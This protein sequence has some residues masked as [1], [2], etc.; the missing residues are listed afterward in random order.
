MKPV[1]YIEIDGVLWKVMPDGQWIAVQADEVVDPTVKYVKETPLP[2]N[3]SDAVNIDDPIDADPVYQRPTTPNDAQSSDQDLASESASLFGFIRPEL[4]EVL[5]QSGYDTLPTDYENTPER[6][7]PDAQFYLLDD[8]ATITVTI[9]DGG[10]GY[11]NALEVPSIAIFGTTTDVEDGRIVQ[12]VLSD[13]SGQQQVFSATVFQGEYRIEGIDA[14]GF[15]EGTL[16]VTATI[17]DELDNFIQA[18]DTTIKDTLAEITTEFDG[19]GDEFFNRF[20]I[21]SSGLTGTVSHVED[22]QRIDIEVIDSL[23]QTLRFTTRVNGGIWSINE[24]LSSLAEGPLTIHA[25][26]IDVAGNP[27]SASDTIV[28]DTQASIT[29]AIDSADDDLVSDAESGNVRVYGEVTNVE[30]GQAIRVVLVDSA[31]HA[32]WF[33]TSVSG[34]Q[35]SI[36]NIDV[37]QF[38]DGDFRVLAM[39]KDVAGNPA[40]AT[41]SA[42]LDTTFPTIDIDTLTGLQII[43][44]K[45]GADTALQGTTSG[46]EAGQPVLVTITDGMNTVEVLT[47]VDAAGN[48]SFDSIDLSTLDAN[49]EWQLNATVTDLAG[50]RASDDMPSLMVPDVVNVNE[51]IAVALGSSD[52][53]SQINIDN[54]DF[55]FID[56]QS[57]L[58]SL[59]SLGQSISVVLSADGLSLSAL[60]ADG[61][62]VLSAHILNNQEV[63]I[64]LFLPVD[65]GDAQRLLTELMIQGTQTDSDGTSETVV[66]PVAVVI[67]DAI[68]FPP[69][70]DSAAITVTIDDGGDGYEN[71]QETPAVVIHGS[72]TDVENLRLVTITVTDVD[73]NTLTFT[74][75]VENNRYQ[76]SPV[77]L[78]GLAEGPLSVEAHIDDVYGKTIQ[79]TDSTIKDTLADITAEFEGN[80]DA[81]LNQFEVSKTVLT[82]RVT[83]VEDGQRIDI[84]VID[85]L[86]NTLTFSTLVAGNTWTIE[87]DLSSLVDGELTLTTQ[88]IDVAGN[89]TTASDTIIKDTQA[90]ITIAIDSGEDEALNPTELSSVTLS[91]VVSHVEDGQAVQVVVTDASGA[92]LVFTTVVVSGAWSLT[93]LDLSSLTDGDIHATARTIDVAGNPATAEDTAIVDTTAP[94]ID[95][96]TLTGLGIVQFKQGTETALQG[97]TTGAEPGQPVVVTISDGTQTI[98]VTTTVDASGLWSFSSIDVS[99]LDAA[100]SWTLTATVTDAAGNSASDETPTLDI[101]DTVALWEDVAVILDSSEALSDINIDN[102]LFTF[103]DTQSDLAALTSLGQSVS[104]VISTDGLSLSLVRG[105]GATVLAAA[106]ETNSQV[107]L[108]LFLPVDHGEAQRL[109]TQIL[110]EGT[111]TD[112][113]GTTETVIAPLPI[114]IED[115]I[116][117]PPLVDSASLTVTIDDGGDGYEN[118]LEVPGTRIHGNTVDVQDLRLVTITVTDSLGAT[119]TFTTRVEN[120]QYQFFPVDLSSLA[121]G[122]LTVEAEI[123][124]AYGNVITAND[125]TIKDTLAEMD[126]AFDGQGD[127]FLNQFEVATTMLNGH[128]ANVEDGQTI[129]IEIIDGQGGRLTFTTVVSGEQWSLEVDLSTLSDGELTVHAQTL[130]VAGNPT[131]SHHTIVKDTQ[132]SI[133]V[134]IESGDDDL[135]NPEELTSVKVGGLV[136][137]IE[138]GQSVNVVLSDSAGNTMTLQTTIVGGAWAIENLDLSGFVDGEI[139]ATVSTVD[140]AGNPATATDSATVDTTAPTID[141]DTLD[142]LNILQFKLGTSTALQGTT[143]GAEAGQPVVV[144]ISDGTQSI[145]ITTSVDAAGNWQF[146]AIDVSDLNN[147]ATWTLT[148]TVTDAAGNSAVDD[149]PTLTF[150]DVVTVYEDL[151]VAIG[152]SGAT[153]DINVEQAQFRFHD[154]QTDLESLTSF[155][156]SITTTLSADGQTL[157]ATRADGEILLT[158]HIASN[159]QVQLQLFLPVDH[160]DSQRLLT[161]LMIAG[162]QTDADGTTETVLTPLPIVIEDAIVFP[163][164]VDSA[165]IA[166]VIDDGGDGY[167]NQFE[168]PAVRI[169]GNTVDVENLRLVTITVTDVDGKVLTFTTRVSDNAYQVSPVDLS[170]LAEGPLTVEAEIHDVYGHSVSASDSTI[171]DTLA[172]ISTDFQG[173]GDEFFNKAEITTSGIAGTV[174]NVEDG[175]RIDIEVIDHLGHRLTFTTTVSGNSWSISEDL[176]ALAEGELIVNTQTIDV[177]GNPTADTDTIVKDTRAVISVNVTSGSDALL[178]ATEVT[179]TDLFGRVFF[180]EEGQTVSVTVTDQAGKVLTFSSTVVN[181]RWEVADADL[182]SLADGPIVVTASVSDVAGNVAT[183]SDS[184]HVIDTL[185]PQIDIDTLD[186]LSVVDFRSGSL[187]TLQ[188]TTSAEENQ[189]V[190]VTITDGTNTLTYT[191]LVDVSGSWTINGVDIASLD[192]NAEWQIQADVTDLAGN[193][194]TDTMPTVIYPDGAVFIE[195]LV[196]ILGQQNAT[197][198]LNIQFGDFAF[199]ADQSAFTEL[200]S[201]GQTI[202]IAISTDGLSLTATRTDGAQVLTAEIVDDQVK[203][204]LKKPLDEIRDLDSTHT[205]LLIQ[206]TQT[207]TDGTSETVVAPVSII[208]LDSQPISFDDHYLTTEGHNEFGNL[209]TNDFDLDAPLLVKSIF[210]NGET[211]VVSQSAPLSLVL[212][213]GIL[214]IYSDGR[215]TMAVSRDLDHSQSQQ[216][217]FSYIAGDKNYD[218]DSA[219]VVIDIHDGEAGRIEPGSQ[220]RTENLL[221]DGAQVVTTSIT[222]TGG[223]DNPDAN[224]LR[225]DEKALADFESLNLTSGES[226]LTLSYQLSSDGKTIS[227]IA[228]NGDVIFTLTLSDAA[229]SGSDVNASLTLTLNRPINQYNGDDVTRLPVTI[230]GT[231]S[232]GT[233]L[234]SG[235]FVWRI[236][237]GT[238]PTLSNADGVFLNEEG[239]LTQSSI[240]DSGSVNVAVGSDPIGSLYFELAGQPTLTSGGEEISYVVSPDGN[241]LQAYVGDLNHLVFE[242]HI[243]E[244]NAENNSLINY[245]FI[246]YRALDQHD[247]DEIDAIPLVITIRDTDGDIQRLPLDIEIQDG[248]QGELTS[249]TLVVTELPKDNLIPAG[250]TSEASVNLVV[251]ADTDPIVAVTLSVSNGQAVVDR[252]NN[253]LTHNGEALVWRVNGDGSYDAIL[254]DGTAVFSVQL[255]DGVNFAPDSTNQVTL[256]VHLYL[257][258]DH[259][260]LTN[261]KQLSVALPVT[262]TDTDGTSVTSNSTLIIFDGETP[263]LSVAGQVVVD[264]HGITD[265]DGIASGSET[266]THVLNVDG[267]SDDVADIQIDIA[268]F[269]AQ[270]FTSGGL[271][272]TLYAQN[273]N[274]WFVAKSSDGEVVFKIRPNNNGKVDFVLSGALDHPDG[275]GTNLLDLPFDMWV[276]DAD[277]DISSTETLTVTVTDDVPIAQNT[278]VELVEGDSYTTNLLPESVMGADGAEISSVTYRGTT[279]PLSADGTPVTIQ[280]VNPNVP[281]EVYGSLVV[282]QDGTFELTTKPN[283]TTVPAISDTLSYVVIDGDGDQVTSTA[284]LVLDDT[285]GILRV[286]DVEMREDEQGALSIVVA[287]GDRDQGETVDSIEIDANSLQGGT[288]YLDGVA[289]NAVGGKVIL[290]GS[291]LLMIGNQV[292]VSGALTYQPATHLA[293]NT[294]TIVLAV[295]AIIASTTGSETLADTINVNVFPVAD[296]PTWQADSQYDYTLVEDASESLSLTLNADLVDSDSSESLSYLISGIP[297]GITIW[298]DGSQVNETTAYSEEELNRMTIR[299][300]TN[301]SGQF[302]FTVTAVATEAGSSFASPSD[303]TAVA[304]QQVTINVRPDADTPSL[305]VKNIAGL[306]DQPLN[307]HDAIK[308]HLTDSDGSETLYYKLEVAEGWNVEGGS[309]LRLEDGTYWFSDAELVAGHIYLIPKED[310]SSVTETLTVKVTAV[311]LESTVDGLVPVTP[312]ANSSTETITIRLTG[313]VDEPLAI[314]GGAGHWGYD[315]ESKVIS[316]QTDFIEDQLIP[317]DFELITSDDDGSEVINIL[318]TG[319][320]DGVMLVDASGQPVSL[321]ISGEDPTTGIIYQVTNSDLANLYLK[322]PEDYSGQLQLSLKVISTEPDGDSGEFPMTVD[323]EIKPQVDENSGSIISSLG[324]EDNRVPLSLWP[325]LGADNDGSEDVIGYVINAPEQGIT[326]YFDGVEITIPTGG[327]DVASLTDSLSPDLESLLNSGR[328][329]AKGP[330]DFSGTLDIPV[331]YLVQDTSG[332]GAIDQKYVDATIAV[333]FDA[334]VELDT[335]L[336]GNPRVLANSEGGAVDLTYA[337]RFVDMDVDGSEYLDYIVIKVPTGLTL[338][339]DHPNGATQDGEGNWV[340]PAH[341]LTSDSVRELAALIL[342]DATISSTQNTE[343]INLVVSARVID[344][345]D[346][347][348][349]DAPIRV[350]FTGHD[351]GGGSCEPVGP[352]GDLTPGDDALQFNEGEDLD[353]SG[354]LDG[355]IGSDPN[356]ELSFFI[357]ADKLPD[358]VMIEGEGVTIEYDSAGNIVGFVI[359]PEAMASLKITGLDEDFAG[360]LSLEVDIKETSGCNGDS[361]TTAQAVDIEILPIVDDMLVSSITTMDED[362]VTDLNLSLILGDSVEAGQ[363][364]S[365]EG[366]S[367][368]GKETINSLM[369]KVPSGVTLVETPAD[370]GLLT[371]NGD[372]TYTINDAARLG[373]I[374]LVPPA[375]YSGDIRLEVHANITDAADCV[376]QTDTQDKVSIITIHIDPVTDAANINA[377]NVLGDEDSYIALSGLDVSL[378]DQ[379]GSETLSVMIKGVPDGA[380]LVY[381]VGASYEL[382]PNNGADGGSFDGMPTS[383]WQLDPSRLADL[384]ILPPLDFSG[385]IPLTINAITQEIGTTDIVH[386]SGSMTV[387]VLPVGDDVQFFGLDS[388]YTG[389]E[390]EALSIPVTISSNETNSDEFIVL[391]LHAELTSDPSALSG[392]DK[393]IVDGHEASFNQHGDGSWVARVIVRASEVG[394]IQLYSGDAFGTLNLTMTAQ[395]FDKSIVLGSLATDLGEAQTQ[396]IV[397]EL[398]PVPDEPILTLDYVTIVAEASGSIPLNLDMSMVNPADGEEGY[399]TISGLPDGLLLSAGSKE[400]GEWLVPVND[401][402]NLSI[403]SGYTGAESFTLTLTP[404]A[405]LGGQTATGL[406]Q[407][408]DVQL[409]AIG[410]S[411][412]TAT[413]GDDLFV[414]NSDSLGSVGDA[415]VD[416]IAGFD[417]SANSDTIDLSAI[418]SG[419]GVSDGASADPFVDLVQTGTDLHINIKTDG[420]NAVQTIVLTDLNLEDYYGAGLTE[421]QILQQMIDDQNLIVQ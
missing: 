396:S 153:S 147:R 382:L 27:A 193:P 236:E 246:L 185:P 309:S 102:A 48:W 235:D 87:A 155:G 271:A 163:P 392:L 280:L 329:T 198:D 63:K 295:S 241:T 336:E 254:S 394:N 143:T 77:D 33:V 86:G 191:T 316:N 128:V 383:E 197:V 232:D 410:D 321:P 133:T 258:V 263:T 70:V 371:D 93:D 32:Q 288:L 211:H 304:S 46:A 357:S 376:A 92:K 200:T 243:Q 261:D 325:S 183:A 178:N 139:S 421:A 272:I 419:L 338:I 301:I 344:G 68:V 245:D 168:V 11:E 119:L 3:D 150:P 106:I 208:V 373:D 252:N 226:L 10:D 40:V 74:T 108:S 350:Q 137:H 187:T 75:R 279:Y 277:G 268:A 225:F 28:K 172:E 253:A 13:A 247:E 318:I 146:S 242:V 4:R 409:L 375:H 273:S 30:D 203:I 259:S 129:N 45:S 337:V 179:A 393:I 5:A 343:I 334:R 71:A 327:L 331:T 91:G 99:A 312:N 39:T 37:S 401:V 114:V 118:A 300:D 59:T 196:G 278:S 366:N 135:L 202:T 83:E 6:E 240:S 249:A 125:A 176:S 22:G 418:L 121:E 213:E 250:I 97:S 38:A 294:A 29:V 25:Q 65:H 116:V 95:I 105:D 407:V 332:T 397:V 207:D 141:I 384:Y 310:I 166:V 286:D 219:N 215:W 12:L 181:G 131:T 417:M 244:P 23:G 227:A 151:T 98:S 84:E 80:G 62:V 57:S 117:F 233:A 173:N 171:K 224:S 293:S 156:Q 113:D 399:L 281:S 130:D 302:T 328:L 165:E 385:D 159:A 101:P 403:V 112:A 324:V 346:A 90:A 386:T 60:R 391:T 42:G 154:V 140:V 229:I 19:R 161:D 381:K 361:V 188:G 339:V 157:T 31:G 262:A 148:A 190:T 54:A 372:G 64:Q 404:S 184:L 138:D 284:T 319:I 360:C 266:V 291:Q 296:V 104:V 132:A 15:D 341:G 322:V 323:I 17:T 348:F 260:K 222:V 311:S 220:T 289:L 412:L 89:V 276:I 149:M 251:S 370:T 7:S 192:Q 364:I 415:T 306:E 79:A 367:A 34:N 274:G 411:S 160:G 51:D 406:S 167:E 326:L 351:D 61:Q 228:H 120:N 292:T 2:I 218:Y 189:T 36:D 212:P 264:E 210:I 405:Q 136:S 199:H 345:E 72:T 270:G 24:D 164:L 162:T 134:E 41:D 308:G 307:L 9:A 195:A 287:L 387:G 142:G 223:S 298:L 124:D 359:P 81:F 56:E 1:L 408:L 420:V 204:S 88:T 402:A 269:N 20:E 388:Q 416:T 354:L 14:S 255:P 18:S 230:T 231:D 177:A 111:Q 400:S 16:T 285:A 49:L 145:S 43:D 67:G 44:F 368:T 180:V 26:T 395:T 115:A 73:G 206:A 50:N 390:G 317:L 363:T 201:Q 194:A 282:H 297:A 313:V 257:P 100:K 398:A 379:D 103:H 256:S 52:A 358:G 76:I 380:V 205:S 356:N 299:S 314:D 109:L 182:S 144:T 53:F 169:H 335:R 340:I 374:S 377:S 275:N 333:N 290:S 352:P 96:D 217:T 214:T 47:Q 107:K 123:H 320:P 353:L 389:M 175:Q 94:T 362:G 152:S 127:A 349:I 110:L 58:S 414:F 55:T 158:A 303:Q 413:S 221:S 66:A 267:G 186:G 315:A 342:K 85:A 239:L 126:V 330:M 347:R 237:D 35:W 234:I 21:S 82:G 8:D 238:N 283:V 248:H 216:V 265:D 378:I 174:S 305:S 355:N 209:L 170:S 365:G 69:L 369:I 122:P 78:T